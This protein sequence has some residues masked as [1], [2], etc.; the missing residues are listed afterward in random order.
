MGRPILMLK[1][2]D[3]SLEDIFL[4]VTTEDKEVS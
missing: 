2:M 3:V 4:E 1:P